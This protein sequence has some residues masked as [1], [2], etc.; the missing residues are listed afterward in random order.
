MQGSCG[1]HDGQVHPRVGEHVQGGHPDRAGAGHVQPDDQD[2][3]SGEVLDEA[4]RALGQLDADEDRRRPAQPTRR[5]DEQGHGQPDQ[6]HHQVGVQLGDGGRIQSGTAGGR[7][8][9]VRAAAGDHRAGR[10][11]HRGH[12]DHEPGQQALRAGHDGLGGRLPGEQPEA[13]RGGDD[14][15][16]DQEVRRHDPGIEHAVYRDPAEY[17]LRGDP[18]QYQPGPGQPVAAAG[19]L[20]V[21]EDEAGQGEAADDADQGSVAVD[22]EPAGHHQRTLVAAGPGR[23]AHA[24]VAEPHDAAGDHD[25]DVG[26]QRGQ[27]GT[28]EQS[29]AVHQNVH[30]AHAGHLTKAVGWIT[31]GAVAVA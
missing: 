25:A 11:Y 26:G 19:E 10:Q 3:Q 12:R 24:G 15:D 2:R 23:A 22:A 8:P 1:S 31:G 5:E 17:R 13:V 6:Q 4:D 18:G 29:G 7:V 16:R 28:A 30:L 9:G 20:G 27:R 14:R 21:G